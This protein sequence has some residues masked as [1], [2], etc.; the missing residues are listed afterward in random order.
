[1]LQDEVYHAQIALDILNLDLHQPIVDGKCNRN[2][3]E[4][5]LILGIYRKEVDPI[6][7]MDVDIIIDLLDSI[8]IENLTKGAKT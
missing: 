1:M 8:V 5:V 3:I 7:Q 2:R 6:N 4:E